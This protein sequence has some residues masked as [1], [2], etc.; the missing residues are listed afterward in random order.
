VSLHKR[1][2]QDVKGTP[3]RPR[4]GFVRSEVLLPALSY[5]IA[6]H[7]DEPLVCVLSLMTPDGPV[8]LSLHRDAASQLGSALLIEGQG[9]AA[10]KG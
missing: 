3:T 10:G 4:P 2:R 7:P 9:D 6:R 1:A 5:Q 8:N